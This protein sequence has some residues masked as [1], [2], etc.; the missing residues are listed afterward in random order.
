MASRL[1]TDATLHQC[2]ES[3]M[4]IIE[5]LSARNAGVFSARS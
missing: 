3:V 1:T 2:P 5:S 4:A